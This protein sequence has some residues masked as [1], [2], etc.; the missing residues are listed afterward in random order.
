MIVLEYNHR[1]EKGSLDFICDTERENEIKDD[2][3][4]YNFG[5]CQE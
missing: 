2:I 3:L 1:V 4:V 5:C